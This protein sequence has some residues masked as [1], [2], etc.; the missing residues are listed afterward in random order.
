MNLQSKRQGLVQPQM[1]A[2]SRLL[3]MKI[4][5]DISYLESKC[6]LESQRCSCCKPGHHDPFE[7]TL[8]LKSAFLQA[9][10]SSYKGCYAKW[11]AKCYSDYCYLAIMNVSFSHFQK[12]FSFSHVFCLTLIRVSFA[13]SCLRSNLFG[14][15][16]RFCYCSFTQSQTCAL[17]L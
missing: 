9:F 1:T 14:L 11:L 8:S 6:F 15:H 17:E 3:L 12:L 5:G 10:H 7:S 4:F 16:C 2:W 13:H